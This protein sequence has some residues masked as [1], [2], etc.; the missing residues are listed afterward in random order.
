MKLLIESWNRFF[1][2]EILKVSDSPAQLSG[3][4]LESI[5]KSALENAQ[6]QEFVVP[7]ETIYQ[8]IVLL[9]NNL[10]SLSGRRSM[11]INKHKED[12]NEEWF[13]NSLKILDDHIERT[14]KDIEDMRKELDGMVK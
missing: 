5:L 4:E 12:K 7:I 14:A 2:E 6:S 3:E 13:K 11:I 9:S 8:N 1:K 10:N